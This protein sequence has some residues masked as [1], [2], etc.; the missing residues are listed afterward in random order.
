MTWSTLHTIKHLKSSCIGVG[1]WFRDL[2]VAE[3]KAQS[4]S[5]NR[6]Y[7]IVDSVCFASGGLQAHG[8]VSATTG[9]L[10]VALVSTDPR[11]RYLQ[12]AQYGI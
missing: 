8:P 7:K 2:S 9:M 1:T 6:Q 10:G 4:Q 12:P 5:S 3:S 11:L